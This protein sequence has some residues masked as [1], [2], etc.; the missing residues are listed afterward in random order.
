MAFMIE[1]KAAVRSQDRQ[2]VF[3]AS[4]EN[5]QING[6]NDCDQTA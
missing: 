4:E 3:A 1:Q 2:S 6:Q 5:S